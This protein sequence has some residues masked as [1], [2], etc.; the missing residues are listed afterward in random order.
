MHDNASFHDSPLFHNN[1]RGAGHR[2]LA[3]PPYR[4]EDGPIEFV[5][6]TL[7]QDLCQR[8]AHIFDGADLRRE[9]GNSLVAMAA[10]GFGRYFAHCGY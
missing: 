8:R 6:N 5:F 3:R 10:Q 4:A 9:V 2:V 7:Q 1:V